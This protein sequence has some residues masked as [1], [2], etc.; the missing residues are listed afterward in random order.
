[1]HI[2]LHQNWIGKVLYKPTE[3][4]LMIMIGLTQNNQMYYILGI[5]TKYDFIKY[6]YFFYILACAN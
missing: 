3:R 4:V 6:V 1:M 2:D 5:K